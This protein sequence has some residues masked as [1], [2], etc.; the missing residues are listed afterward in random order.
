MIADQ[1]NERNLTHVGSTSGKHL[2]VGSWS[3]QS[4]SALYDSGA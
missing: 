1:A 2:V 4:K 3:A